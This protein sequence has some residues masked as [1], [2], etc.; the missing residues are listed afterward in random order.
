[1]VGDEEGLASLGHVGGPSLNHFVHRHFFAR[2]RVYTTVLPVPVDGARD[3]PGAEVVKG[4]ALG[5]VTLSEIVRERPEVARMAGD[6]G[7]ERA[8]WADRAELAVIAYG[9]QFRPRSLNRRQQPPDV[10]VR[11]HRAFVEDQDMARA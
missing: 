4:M 2:G 10:G 7:F 1:M 5:R 3:V 6:E 9:D 11:G 8:A